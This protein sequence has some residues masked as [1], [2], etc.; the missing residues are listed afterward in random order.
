MAK[1]VAAYCHREGVLALVCGTYG[2][3]IRL[4]PPLVICDELLNDALN[5]LEQ[6]ITAVSDHAIAEA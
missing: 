6:A 5:V 3:V 2:N 4:L 1:A